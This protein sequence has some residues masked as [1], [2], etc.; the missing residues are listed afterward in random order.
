[1]YLTQHNIALRHIYMYVHVYITLYTIYVLNTNNIVYVHTE[2]GI[3]KSPFQFCYSV[4]ACPKFGEKL[5]LRRV[6]REMDIYGQNHSQGRVL[7]A[8]VCVCVCVCVC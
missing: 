6:V 4:R 1:M 3:H 2:M 5:E 8:S 7:G